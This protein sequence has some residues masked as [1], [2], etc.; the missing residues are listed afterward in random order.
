MEAHQITVI[1]D[2]D[3]IINILNY[4][5]YKG[6]T[7]STY[8]DFLM[9]K[10]G[11]I[12]GI[13]SRIFDIKKYKDELFMKT[14]GFQERHLNSKEWFNY[15]EYR[16]IS[17]GNTSVINDRIFQ[18]DVT[19]SLVCN[20][21][22]PCSTS[23][24]I[25]KVKDLKE[26][27]EYIIEQSFGKVVLSSCLLQVDDISFTYGICILKGLEE[28][29]DFLKFRQK[30]SYS[31]IIINPTDYDLPFDYKIP[32]EL[33]ERDSLGKFKEEFK[34]FYYLRDIIKFMLI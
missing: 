10:G 2:D 12:S 31:G 25:I 1:G 26:I 13:K 19:N 11:D 22:L 27:Y 5:Y 7:A 23:N 17:E 4:I 3:R 30:F 33:V 21:K 8:A 9:T 15:Q 34:L 32:S 18:S 29:Q 20:S 24:P 28:L 16:F 14:F 6:Y